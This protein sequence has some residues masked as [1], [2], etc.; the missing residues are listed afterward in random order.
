MRV[1]SLAERPD[2]IDAMWTM[3][4]LWPTFMLHDPYGDIF[5]SRLPDVFPEFQLVAI[6]DADTVIGKINS[7][8]FRWLG[9]DEDLPDTG[10]DGIQQRG[11]DDHL[12]G[13]APTAVSLLEAR[14]IPAHQGAG[15]SRELLDAARERVRALGINDLF[16]PVRPTAKT[17]EPATPMTE[18][19]TRTRPDGLP[20]DP[21]IRTHVRLGAR[22]V[23][24]C[25][26]SMTIP[27]RC[28]SG[29][30]GPVGRS[31]SPVRRQSPAPSHWCRSTSPRTTRS[32]S[33]RTCGCTTTSADRRRV[34]RSDPSR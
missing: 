31:P 7:I 22:I 34:L 17:T 3:P 15:M 18:Y 11:F 8:P 21:W 1:V 16:G 32:T 33:R 27:A 20:A 25:P 14:I 9:T 13:R 19:V 30:A 6:D 26:L 28:R 24:V 29:R 5:F 12:H 4:N 2:L 23:K 10:W